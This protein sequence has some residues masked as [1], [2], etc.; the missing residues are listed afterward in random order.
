MVADGIS[1]FAATENSRDSE[2]GDTEMKRF[3]VPAFLFALVVSSTGCAGALTT[4]PVKGKDADVF[5]M[6]GQWEGEYSSVDTGRKGTIRFSLR[7]GRKTADGEV[8]MLLP[9]SPEPRMLRIAVMRIQGDEVHGKLERY[10]DPSCKCDVDTDFIGTM[11]DEAIDG[12]FIMRPVGTDKQLG[13]V[14]H[15][16]RK[17]K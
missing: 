2:K 1:L 6:R 16:E 17:T 8:D 15:A 11:S 5:A 14:W 4:V 7:P 12:T 3:M 9:G 10:T 13:G